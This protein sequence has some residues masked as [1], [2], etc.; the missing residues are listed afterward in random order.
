MTVASES[1]AAATSSIVTGLF[2]LVTDRRQEER[3]GRREAADRLIEDLV[4]VVEELRLF[5]SRRRPQR[6]KKLMR[7]LYRTLDELE[8]ALPREWRHLKRSLRDCVGNAVGGGI[9][10]VDHMVVPSDTE[11]AT[12]SRWTM[13][14]A[15]Y[16]EE[17]ARTIRW[18]GSSH[19]PRKS[20]WAIPTFDTWVRQHQLQD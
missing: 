16:L 19:F 17:C 20:Q 1:A 18:W 9:V 5:A 6:W 3:T 8:P 14:A 4:P 11:L 10:F 15:D 12:F 13:H 2:E 7:G